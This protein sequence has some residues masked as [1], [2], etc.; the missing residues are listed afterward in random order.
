MEKGQFDTLEY[1]V[2]LFEEFISL[3]TSAG[4]E[5]SAETRASV[6]DLSIT[7][8]ER[9]Q[10]S[11]MSKKMFTVHLQEQIGVENTSTLITLKV[12]QQQSIMP[13]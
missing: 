6:V 3:S 11:K 4:P 2:K 9:E 13:A 5:S 8:S 1:G 12:M 7:L 10:I